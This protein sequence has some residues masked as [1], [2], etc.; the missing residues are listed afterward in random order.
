M[1]SYHISSTVKTCHPLSI[2]M[3][4][5][6]CCGQPYI[7][8]ANGCETLSHTRIGTPG[9]KD[10]TSINGVQYQCIPAVC[11]LGMRLPTFQ[12]VYHI[13]ATGSCE[14]QPPR[15]IILHLSQVHCM[16]MITM[17]IVRMFVGLVFLVALRFVCN[18]TSL[19]LPT[20]SIT[21]CMHLAQFHSYVLVIYTG[22]VY[23]YSAQVQ[24]DGS[25]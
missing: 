16:K 5:D 2:V 9:K 20:S 14:I 18:R 12:T 1:C 6:S 11:D 24:C 7:P 4:T 25:D 15:T 8:L 10:V 17:L 13:I 21:F 19:P 3:A 22:M 23:L